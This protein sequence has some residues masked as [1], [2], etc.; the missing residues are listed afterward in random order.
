MLKV[1]PGDRESVYHAPIGNS[2]NELVYG[3]GALGRGGGAVGLKQVSEICT[4]GL[5]MKTVTMFRSN[6]SY[7]THRRIGGQGRQ[8]EATFARSARPSAVTS[9]SSPKRVLLSSVSSDSHTWNLVFIQLLL[10]HQGHQVINLGACTPYEEILEACRLHRPD[11]LVI[12][13]VNG[14]GNIDGER[15][16]SHLRRD[17]DLANLPT[18]IGGQLGVRGIEGQAAMTSRLLAAGFDAVFNANTLPMFLDFVERVSLP[19]PAP[20]LVGVAS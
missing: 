2:P 3:E 1:R 19:A 10:E 15:L 6:E 4:G 16:I 12:S 18:V 14:H 20:R 11:L 8:A 13:T 5:R 17:P 9:H 7:G